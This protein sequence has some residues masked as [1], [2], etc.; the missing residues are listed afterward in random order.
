MECPPDKN[1]VPF[2]NDDVVGWEVVAMKRL[3]DVDYNHLRGFINSDCVHLDIQ[4]YT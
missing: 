3:C 2:N 1:P 4:T